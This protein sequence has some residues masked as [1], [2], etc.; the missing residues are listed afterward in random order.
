MNRAQV[1]AN[2]DGLYPTRPTGQKTWEAVGVGKANNQENVNLPAML[3]PRQVISS[4]SQQQRRENESGA[5]FSQE[6]KIRV[7]LAVLFASFMLVGSFLIVA[8]NLYFWGKELVG[9]PVRNKASMWKTVIAIVIMMGIYNGLTWWYEKEL[10]LGVDQFENLNL[11]SSH[12]PL[13][14]FVCF[15][16]WAGYL[17]KTRT[18]QHYG[19]FFI[20]SLAAGSFVYLLSKLRLLF[21]YKLPLST[22]AMQ[23]RNVDHLVAGDIKAGDFVRD[24]YRR[25]ESPP[26][27]PN[28]SDA[29]D[30][31]AARMRSQR[32]AP[33]EG[34][35]ANYGYQRSPMDA[36]G[37]VP[38]PESELM[39]PAHLMNFDK[40]AVGEYIR[41]LGGETPNQF[42]QAHPYYTFNAN[43][44]NRNKIDDSET[45]FGIASS[46][47]QMNRKWI[48]RQPKIEQGGAKTSHLK[49]IAPSAT[50]PLEKTHPWMAPDEL[51]V[52]F[53]AGAVS[54]APAERAVG[55]EIREIHEEEE[56]EKEEREERKA[57]GGGV[58]DDDDELMAP[59]PRPDKMKKRQPQQQQQ[60]LSKKRL[61]VPEEMRPIETMS[62][63]KRRLAGIP[64]TADLPQEE[65][66]QERK[67]RDEEDR[68]DANS[69]SSPLYDNHDD[70]GQASDFASFFSQKKQPTEKEINLEIENTT[71]RT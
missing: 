56:E 21:K 53:I 69:L 20:V 2:K 12:L 38:L 71:K 36:T 42:Y 33:F 68:E 27:Y 30:D 47:M 39:R 34:P 63:R 9:E 23:G 6:H 24:T 11:I 8:N 65:D 49:D 67:D 29:M 58:D 15:I 54:S 4:A 43:W 52:A 19:I 55:A 62:D 17:A 59:P 3:E 1:L 66:H 18:K 25:F 40:G 16:A 57:R 51:G 45:Q 31:F 10:T 44:P 50:E 70:D 7:F 61:E 32:T 14:L 60:P 46:P 41:Q 35:R 48:Y 64:G 13:I 26:V 28:R 37:R 5:A 22:E